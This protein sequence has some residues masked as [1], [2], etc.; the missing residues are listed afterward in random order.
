EEAQ[1]IAGDIGG[2]GAL[3]LLAEPVLERPV[4]ARGLVVKPPPLAVLLRRITVPLGANAV[5]VRVDVDQEARRPLEE[6]LLRRRLRG[7][8]G[9]D[10]VGARRLWLRRRLLRCLGVAHV[11]L[12]VRVVRALYTGSEA[13][14]SDSKPAQRGGDAGEHDFD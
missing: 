2:A 8:D 9:L 6:C 10:V 1:P 13:R 11:I 4:R 3:P 7:L 5:L 12:R 14:G